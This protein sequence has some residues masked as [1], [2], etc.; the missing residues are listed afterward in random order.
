MGKLSA[1]F[2][3]LMSSVGKSKFFYPVPIALLL[4]VP[5]FYGKAAGEDSSPKVML[6]QA[7]GQ[8]M[9]SPD[10]KSWEKIY[11][12]RFLYEGY[13][14]KTG[15]DGTCRF[16]DPQRQTMQDME[17]DTEAEIRAS[18]IR[19]RKGRISEPASADSIM[20]FLQRKFTRVRKYVIIRREDAGNP[21]LKT[22]PDICLSADYPDL[23]WENM[24]PE[25]AYRLVAGEKTYDVP[26]SKT[27]L[28]RFRLTGIQPGIYSF[29][30]R[31]MYQGEV[32]VS[33][34]R[35]GTLRWLSD[36][37]NRLFRERERKI[38]EIDPDNGF[39]LGNVM[40]EYGFTVAAMD[41]FRQFL[42]ENPEIHE[43]RPF[44]IKIY[45]E[46]GLERLRQSESFFYRQHR[47]DIFSRR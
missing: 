23:V 42:A 20:N 19:V 29:Y 25:Y 3:M 27:D 37:E 14:V 40:D 32:I 15:K 1:G 24:G 47:P 8:V 22:V 18:G 12:N 38:R 21:E 9:Y 46:L 17:N 43:V 2:R 33:S 7:A 30:I 34:E 13:L 26:A 10:G 5:V 44:L 39:L 4:F 6:I 35:N 45:S 31:V 16:F 36:E 28:V 11:R 41:Q